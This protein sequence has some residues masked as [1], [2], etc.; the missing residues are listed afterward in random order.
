MTTTTIITDL[1]NDLRIALDTKNAGSVL[2]FY[3]AMEKLTIMEKY[4]MLKG[5]KMANKDAFYDTMKINSDVE[6]SRDVIRA[7]LADC[8]VGEVNGV[9]NDSVAYAGMGNINGYVAIATTAFVGY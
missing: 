1:Y 8:Y 2:A 7:I 5:F 3:I 4:Y 9:T 6:R